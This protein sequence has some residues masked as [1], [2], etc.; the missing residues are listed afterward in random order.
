MLSTPTVTEIATD[1]PAV[2]AFEF[3]GGARAEDVAAMARHMEAVFD[4]GGEVSIL[5]RMRDY[6]MGDAYR[7]TGLAT[8]QAQM[9]SPWHVA[10]YAVVGAPPAAR[11]MI[12]TMPHARRRPHLRPGGRARRLGLRRRQPPLTAPGPAASPDTGAAPN[13]GAPA[14]GHAAR[15]ARDCR[16]GLCITQTLT[17]DP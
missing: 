11:A 6:D 2:H 9:R 10:K 4:Q 15:S 17:A 12:E 3:R 13:K 8:M 7:S 16:T 1:N 5:L 14:R